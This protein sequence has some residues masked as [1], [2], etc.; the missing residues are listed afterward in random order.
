MISS[1]VK[2][3]S[4][5]RCLGRRIWCNIHRL[6]GP[7][8]WQR[9]IRFGCW[10]TNRLWSDREIESAQKSNRYRSAG[11]PG[12]Q[13]TATSPP[14]LTARSIKRYGSKWIAG[15]WPCNRRV[16]GSER[17]YVQVPEDERRFCFVLSCG[18]RDAG[19]GGG[20]GSHKIS[21]GRGPTDVQ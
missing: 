14:T 19:S 1:A 12:G 17:T 10:D 13:S 16:A 2:A 15:E 7:V 8:F 4:R 11:S 3:V 21:E 18:M 20:A 6:S 9:L 5:L